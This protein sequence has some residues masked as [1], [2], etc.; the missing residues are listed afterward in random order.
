M[1]KIEEDSLFMRLSK[2]RKTQKLDFIGLSK[3][4]QFFAHQI[5]KP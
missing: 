5:E 3:K 2:S 4:G 1:N